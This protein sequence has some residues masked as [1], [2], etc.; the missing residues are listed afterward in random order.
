[1][2]II[3]PAECK[4]EFDNDYN[5]WRQGRKEIDISVER[6]VTFDNLNANVNLSTINDVPRK[7]SVFV[8]ADFIKAYPKW[9]AFKSA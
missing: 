2:E 5:S 4:S 7:F 9:S 8:N 1:M 6:D 3:I